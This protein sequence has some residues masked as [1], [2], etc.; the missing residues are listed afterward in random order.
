LFSAIFV[1]CH[2]S[3]VALS[4]K[5]EDDDDDDDDGDAAAAAADDHGGGR[6]TGDIYTDNN[7]STCHCIFRL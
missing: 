2:V 5:D 3:V 7:K 4:D 6:W 1:G